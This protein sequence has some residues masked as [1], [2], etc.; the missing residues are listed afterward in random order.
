MFYNST[1][2]A[3]G[4]MVYY[5]LIFHS[6]VVFLNMY[7]HNIHTN[8]TAVNCHVTLELPRG[9]GGV[10]ASPIGFSDLKFEPFKQSK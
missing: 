3:I 5:I 4:T 9:G 8:K 1:Y 6:T 10:K 2:K 7:V